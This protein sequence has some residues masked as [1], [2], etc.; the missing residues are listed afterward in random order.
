MDQIFANRTNRTLYD[1][2]WAHEGGIDEVFIERGLTANQLVD[3][4]SSPVLPTRV[5]Y[6]TEP[7]NGFFNIDGGG[8]LIITRS[9]VYSISITSCFDETARTGSRQHYIGLD[10]AGTQKIFG[11]Q[12]QSSTSQAPAT[13]MGTALT[14][15]AA[16]SLNIGDILEHK[17][18]AFNTAGTQAEL[19]GT[20]VS[21]ITYTRITLIYLGNV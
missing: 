16:I 7:N 6:T 13:N 2:K 5:V 3:A 21:A 18:G 20:N 9:G 19:I 11:F 12:T 8:N 14:S 15:S 1:Y 4:L 10:R 17:I